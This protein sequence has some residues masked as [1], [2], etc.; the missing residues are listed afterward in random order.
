[1][2]ADT[3]TKVL[4]SPLA[5]IWI[6]NVLCGFVKGLTC[7]ENIN[8][9]EV[10]GISKLNLQQVP[11][12]GL[13]QTAQM[14]FFFI[15]LKRPEI[16]AFFMRDQGLNVLIDTLELGEKPIN[17][18]VYRKTGAT[19]PTTGVVLESLVTGELLWEILDFFPNSHT[20]NVTDNQ[21]SST[22]VSGLY[23]TP[24]VFQS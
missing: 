11:P 3:R 19:H 14:E 21:I 10:Q 1:M 22:N 18:K 8:R 15:S 4:T 9:G 20:W 17:L 12:M 5:S 23:L 7:T 24:A 16:R 13:R 6:N 2:A